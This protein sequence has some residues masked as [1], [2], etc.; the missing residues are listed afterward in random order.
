MASG[1]TVEHVSTLIAEDLRL[2]LLDSTAAVVTVT[3]A[4]GAAGSAGN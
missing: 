1:A 4:T 3:A 2:L